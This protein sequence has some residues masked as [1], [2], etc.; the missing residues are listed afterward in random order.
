MINRNLFLTSTKRHQ[1]LASRDPL[2]HSA[3]IYSVITTKIYCRPTCPS[4]LARRANIVFHENAE[5]AERD[6][7]RACRRCRPNVDEG[8]V[9]NQAGTEIG[10]HEK[11]LAEDAAE[12]IKSDDLGE[13]GRGK[14]MVDKAMKLIEIEMEDGV[15]KWTVKKMAKEVGFTESHFCRVFKKETGMTMGEYRMKA[16]DGQL[17]KVPG[18]N[19]TPRVGD[20]SLGSEDFISWDVSWDNTNHRNIPDTSLSLLDL[21][22]SIFSDSNAYDGMEFLD[23]ECCED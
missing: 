3:F 22:S 9:R 1:A 19:A 2:A 14:R 23:L 13:M 18:S 4:R 6:G 21:H 20:V 12:A 16:V 10:Y 15:K 11:N 5:Q 17:G 7:F 8:R